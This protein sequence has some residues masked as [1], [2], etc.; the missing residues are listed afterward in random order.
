MKWFEDGDAICVTRD[1]FINLQESP[2][3]F[4]PKDSDVGRMILQDG[5]LQLPMYWLRRL[6]D[7]LIIEASRIGKR[8]VE[9]SWNFADSESP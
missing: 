3:V 1:D 6:R 2:A 7:Y 4:V 5:L 8:P 9:P